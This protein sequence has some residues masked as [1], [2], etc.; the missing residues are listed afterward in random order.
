MHTL[1]PTTRTYYTAADADGNIVGSGYVDPGQTIT[2]GADGFATYPTESA[3]RSAL[4]AAGFEQDY[5][6]IDHT[7]PVET[8]RLALCARVNAMRAIKLAAPV[9]YNGN[10]FDNDL[11]A[12][13]NVMGMLSA[14]QAGLPLP[15]GFTWRTSENTNVPASAAF[16]IGLA[17]AML[18]HRN[19]CYQKSWTL[20]AAINASGSPLSID[21]VTGWPG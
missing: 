9:S 8:Q 4:L 19:A 20:K 21:V 14:I 10:T 3:M 6:D 18:A 7:L 11:E 15:P 17:G 1:S 13:D 2:C 5:A 16:I 12:R